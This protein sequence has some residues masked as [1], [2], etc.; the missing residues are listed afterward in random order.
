MQ[1]A[2]QL[3]QDSRWLSLAVLLLSVELVFAANG[4]GLLVNLVVLSILFSLASFYLIDR[5][6]VWGM[7]VL[8]AATCMVPFVVKVF[9]IWS[10]PVQT[11]IE[12]IDL[13]FFLSLAIK[14]KLRG[15]N[16]FIGILIL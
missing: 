11:F 7:L 10:V 1:R 14:K 13:V 2:V 4:L 8:L 16:T 6:P 12:M 5:E 15:R 3:L 9:K